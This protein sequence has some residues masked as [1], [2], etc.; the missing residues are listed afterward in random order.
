MR[1][2]KKA[3]EG[4]ET[5][6]RLGGGGATRSLFLS[7]LRR[8]FARALHAILWLRRSVVLPTKPPCYAGY[9]PSI[10]MGKPEISVGKLNGQRHLLESF[11]KYG[12]LFK[13]MQF[14]PPPPP[15]PPLLLLLPFLCLADWDILCSG[16]SPITL[17]FIFKDVQDF[18]GTF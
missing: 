12:L 3:G 7:R 18:K 6:R 9:L 11:K 10:Y 2:V 13:A 8:S 4:R 15:T 16:S 5:A 17:N 14:L 1:K